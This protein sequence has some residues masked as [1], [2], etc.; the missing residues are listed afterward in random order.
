MKKTK[1]AFTIKFKIGKFKLKCLNLQELR[2]K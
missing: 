2:A 1:W